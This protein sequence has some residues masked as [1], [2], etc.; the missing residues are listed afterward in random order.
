[1]KLLIILAI[2]YVVFTA[3]YAPDVL[4][5]IVLS[6]I[7]FFVLLKFAPG[8]LLVLMIV[9]III[10]VIEFF[11]YEIFSLIWILVILSIIGMV[12]G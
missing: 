8:L 10:G 2:L 11:M 4:G 1:M 9:S 3:F 5:G 7:I 12:L 6:L